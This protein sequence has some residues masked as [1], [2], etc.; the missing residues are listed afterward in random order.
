MN[1]P[2]CLMWF[3][4]LTAMLT[5]AVG[6]SESTTSETTAPGASDAAAEL[7]AESK[8][9]IGFSALELKNPFFKIIGQGPQYL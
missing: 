8:G 2:G 3:F 1:R 9:T 7:G 6:C 4:F 5:Y